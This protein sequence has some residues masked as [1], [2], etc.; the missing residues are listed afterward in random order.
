[1]DGCNRSRTDHRLSSPILSTIKEFGPGV[2]HDR[3]SLSLSLS[4]SLKD[5][6]DGWTG[7]GGTPAGEDGKH[8]A[9]WY[10]PGVY[11]HG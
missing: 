4:L 7:R 8:A 2:R 6:A 11:S 10:Y 9:A 5:P 3:R 1:M